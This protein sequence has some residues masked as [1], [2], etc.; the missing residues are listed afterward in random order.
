MEKYLP[1]YDEINKNFSYDSNT[2]LITRKLRV[3]NCSKVG[4]I[5]GY[6]NDHG[7]VIIKYLGDAY[8]AHRLAWL[9][10]YKVWPEKD[11]DHIDGNKSNNSIINLRDVSRSTNILNTKHT[12]NNKS[13]YRGVSIHNGKWRARLMLNGVSKI[14]G[15]YDTP[16]EA[17]EAYLEYKASL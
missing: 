16:E 3:A 9:L 4:E 14:I 2:G 17:S 5:A 7:Y 11:I 12:S 13:G 8:K 10:H 15:M 6:I 1:S